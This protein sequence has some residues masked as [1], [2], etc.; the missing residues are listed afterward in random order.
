MIGRE[1]PVQLARIEERRRGIKG[2]PVIGGRASGELGHLAPN[3]R[4]HGRIVRDPLVGAVGE[5]DV[6]VGPADV[7]G[8][9]LDPFASFDQGGAGDD[10]VGLLGHEELVRDDRHVAAPGDAVPEHPRDLGDAVGG[11]ERVHLEDVAGPELARECLRLFGEEEPGAVDQID[12]RKAE[13]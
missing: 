9:D 7:E 13:A 12:D 6:D 5:V 2:V 8:G 1:K 10:H 4:D 3:P 11:E